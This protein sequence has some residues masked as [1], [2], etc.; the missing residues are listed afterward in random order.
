M[1]TKILILLL[2]LSLS[3][4]GETFL[5]KQWGYLP[6]NTLYAKNMARSGTD[7]FWKTASGS[8]PNWGGTIISSY[9]VVPNAVTKV[10]VYLETGDRFHIAVGQK[11]VPLL[12][13][14]GN[15]WYFPNTVSYLPQDG[16]KM[17]DQNASPYASRAYEGDNITMTIDLR[18]YRGWVSYA[19]NGLDMG[20]AF[21]GLNDW[22]TDVYIMFGILYQ[23][24]RLKILEYSVLE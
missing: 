19:K 11:N 14:K 2:A 12:Y 16:S 23:N 7:S 1:N 22:G 24:H 15:P 8:D 21:S 17:V 3:V 20:I 13:S 18:T 10:T 4:F 5:P 9:P 6:M